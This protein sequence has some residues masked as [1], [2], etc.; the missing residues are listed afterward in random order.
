MF[1]KEGKQTVLK[2]QFWK[3]RYFLSSKF[4]SLGYRKLKA[5]LVIGFKRKM[6]LKVT[7]QRRG[8][9]SCRVVSSL[10]KL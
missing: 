1:F 2:M 9:G 6:E 10:L 4:W 8:K 3:T 5:T 7:W